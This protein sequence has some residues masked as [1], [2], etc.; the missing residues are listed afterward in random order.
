MTLLETIVK[1]KEEL[2]DLSTRIELGIIALIG[3]VYWVS[4]R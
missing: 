3:W 4:N 2:K 1:R